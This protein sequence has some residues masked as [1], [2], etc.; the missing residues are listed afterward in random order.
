MPK[1]DRKMII[2]TVNSELSKGSKILYLGSIDRKDQA[3][4]TSIDFY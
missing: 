3:I 4:I 1:D 2:F